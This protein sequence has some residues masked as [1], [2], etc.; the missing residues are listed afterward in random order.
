MLPTS[1]I[2]SDIQ[3]GLPVDVA[4]FRLSAYADEGEYPDEQGI[5]TSR[6]LRA[7]E[8][9]ESMTR[10]SLKRATYTCEWQE[11]PY[12]PRSPRDNPLTFPGLH[13]SIT[14]FEML[15]KDGVAT[16]M[17]ADQWRALPAS[18]IG[19]IR[20]VPASGRWQ[21]QVGDYY[22]G[23]GY[24]CDYSAAGLDAPA[25]YRVVGTAGCLPETYEMPG[26]FFE[27]TALVF[28]YLWMT[29]P[30]SLAVGEEPDVEVAGRGRQCMIESCRRDSP[31]PT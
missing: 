17:P 3:P 5:F 16:A 9:V 7:V 29:Q 8:V 21:G 28:Q 22:Y 18:E 11:L 30:E 19:S 26:P 12:A 23:Y 6:I 1:K 25:G 10:L 13:G 2:A 20:I 4:R 15:D 31:P 24:D 27:G 14:S